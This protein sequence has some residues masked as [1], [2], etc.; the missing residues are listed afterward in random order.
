MKA[1]FDYLRARAWTVV[2]LLAV[3]LLGFYSKFYHG[4]AS[5]WVQNSLGGVFYE[6]FWCLFIFLLLQESRLWLI[7]TIVLAATCLLEFV[8]LW[9]NG[10]LDGIR[11]NFFGRSL[12]GNAFSWLDFPYYFFG[13]GVAWLWMRRLRRLE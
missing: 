6:I 13:C 2:S 1:L 4:P 9:H 3:L 12:I 10:F 11:R 8:Q 5:S 7:V